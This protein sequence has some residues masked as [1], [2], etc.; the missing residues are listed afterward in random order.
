MIRNGIPQKLIVEYKIISDMKDIYNVFNKYS[1]KH[2]K[3]TAFS[4]IAKK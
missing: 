4:E 1:E 3:I 2:A